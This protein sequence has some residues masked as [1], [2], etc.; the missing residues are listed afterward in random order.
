[1]L[2]QLRLWQLSGRPEF[3]DRVRE[4]ADGLADAAREPEDGLFWPIPEDFDSVLAGS[5]HFG[6]AHGVAGVGAFL[7]AAGQA[8][9]ERRYLD[10][11]EAAGRTLAGAADLDE[12]TGAAT[13]RTDRN[14]PAGAKDMLLHWCNGASGVGTFLVRLAA[15]RPEPEAERYWQLVHAAAIAVHQARWSPSPAHCHGLAGNGQFLLDAADL[16]GRAGRPQAAVYRGWAEDLAAVVAA[17]AAVVGG[18]LVVPDET[19]LRL[20]AGYGT[21]LAGPLDFLLRLSH[22]GARS[23][24]IEAG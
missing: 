17:R 18:R 23:W 1:G 7:L 16:A 9:G 10:L 19:G 8:C 5:W 11:A 20:G 2:A 24:M 4:C 3:L 6:F 22:G 12:R 13:W 15:A 21:G 14:Q